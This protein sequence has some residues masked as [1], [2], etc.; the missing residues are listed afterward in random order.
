MILQSFIPLSCD[1]KMLFNYDDMKC[2]I[3]TALQKSAK[4]YLKTPKI[5]KT[6]I[7]VWLCVICLQWQ[8]CI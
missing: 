7:F 3:C 2:T 5:P 1:M 4:I 8:L 6:A